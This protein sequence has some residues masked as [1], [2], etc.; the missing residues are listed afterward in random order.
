MLPLEQIKHIVASVDE[1]EAEDWEETTREER[2]W[3]KI[4]RELGNSLLHFYS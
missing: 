1:I 3:M 4:A 2:H